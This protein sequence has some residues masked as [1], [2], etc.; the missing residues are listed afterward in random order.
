MQLHLL[1]TPPHSEE[2]SARKDEFLNGMLKDILTQLAHDA[3]LQ[4]MGIES[5]VTKALLAA[6]P[7]SVARELLV[8]SESKDALGVLGATLDTELNLLVCIVLC[9]PRAAILCPRS[10]DNPAYVK[11]VLFGSIA[12]SRVR[13]YE[14]T[15]MFLCCLLYRGH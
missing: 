4:G 12:R 8:F 5:A 11:E 7:S 15:C 1:D 2:R 6:I 14:H 3:S 13:V 9:Y 10:T